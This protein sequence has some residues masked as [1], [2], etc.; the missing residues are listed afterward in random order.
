MTP[1]HPLDTAPINASHFLKG[2][3]LGQTDAGTGPPQSH[4][5]QARPHLWTVRVQHDPG[6]PAGLSRVYSGKANGLGSQEK[7][8]DN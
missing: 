1:P 5:K 3:A 2:Q 7:P 6:L 4:G 8:L